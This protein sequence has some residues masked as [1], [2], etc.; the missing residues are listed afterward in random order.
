MPIDQASSP[1]A[2]PPPPPS[3]EALLRRLEQLGIDT[4]THSHPPLHTVEESKALRGQLPGGHCK[5]L[6]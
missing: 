1:T 2:D 3:P 5:N 4:T 6:F